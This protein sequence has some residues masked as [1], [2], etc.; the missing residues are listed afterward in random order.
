MSATTYSAAVNVASSA[1]GSPHSVG[2]TGTGT[3]AVP[4]AP[5]VTLAPDAVDFGTLPLNTSSAKRS[6]SLTNSGNAPLNLNGIAVGGAGAA[7]FAQTNNCPVGGSLAA[8]L[9]CT[10]SLT[11]TP[12]VAGARAAS[13]TV[14][15]NAPGAP[16][17]DLKGMGVVQAAAVAQVAPMQVAFGSIRLGKTSDERKVKVRNTGTTL[18]MIASVT[19]TGDYLLKNECKATLPPGEACEVKVQF[20]PT[21]LGARTGALTVASNAAGSPHAVTLTGTGATR[22]AKGDDDDECE[23]ESSCGRASLP[24]WRRPK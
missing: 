21:A 14:T 2:V 19:V 15:S 16:A 24:F 22:P 8:G 12:T 6:V 20:K 9:A 5:Q 3:A 13:L 4:L 17:V 18:L 1:A 7:D 10:V 23:E 11:F